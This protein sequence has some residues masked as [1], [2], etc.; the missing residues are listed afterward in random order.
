[1]DRKAVSSRLRYA[2]RR[3]RQQM[4]DACCMSAV[5]ICHG[6][7]FGDTCGRTAA[8]A[9]YYW[10]RKKGGVA[11]NWNHYPL[12]ALPALLIW[13][14]ASFLALADRPRRVIT[15]VLSYLGLALYLSFPVGLW[16]TF[17]HPPFR[18]IG[19]TRMWYVFFLMLSGIAVYHR[20]RYRW[21]LLFSTLFS[22]VFIVLVMMTSDSRMQPLVPALQS[23]WFVPHV[24]VYMFSYGIFGCAAIMSVVGIFQR[25]PRYLPFVD[26]LMRIAIVF[27]SLGMLSGCVWAKQAW[28]EYWSWDPKET[29]AAATWL[30]CLAYIHRSRAQKFKTIISSYLLVILTFLLLQMCWY[31]ISFLPSASGSLHRY[32]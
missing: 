5:A 29:W 32:G 4:Q 7:R 15:L 13:L 6:C 9:F 10:N 22:S 21:L 18:T 14:L 11:M 19:D 3:Y 23:V 26:V 1:M 20:L 25:S 2:R 24:S 16:F 12:F 31:G 8:D 27:L 28:G 30:V 17:R